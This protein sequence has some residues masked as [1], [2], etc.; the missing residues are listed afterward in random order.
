MKVGTDGTLLGAWA[1]TGVADGRILDVGTGTG[2]IALMMAQRFPRCQV[3]AID[4]DEAAVSQA[5]QNVGE[6]PFPDRIH[7]LQADVTTFND[8]DGFDAIVS[9]PPYFHQSLEC[10]DDRRTLARHTSSL[11]YNRLMEAAWRLLRNDGVLSFI[12]PDD[13]RARL[14][15]EACLKGFFL[16]R[17]CAVR[18]TPKKA[19]KRYLMEFRKYP[20][21]ELDKQEGVIEIYP[22]VRSE[23]YQSLTQ[24]FY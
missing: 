10:P 12:I 22:C 14:E 5:Q 16:T 13:C 4:I 24:D 20:I 18:T 15:A 6:S 23:W 9:N 2:L 19:P 17:L 3:T 1:S 21:D 11:S 8:T 7:V